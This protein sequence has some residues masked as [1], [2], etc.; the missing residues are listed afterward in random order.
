[1][2]N[3]GIIGLG[4]ISNTHIEAISRMPKEA[5]LVAVCDCNKEKKNKV[6][7]VNF[8]EN[9]E[10]MLQ[11]ERLDCL[12]ICLPH[13][14]HVPAVKLT[15]KYKVPVFVEKPVGLNTADVE[16]LERDEHVK[17]IKVG[18]CLQ[19]RYNATT[20]KM[21]EIIKGGAYGRLKGSKA[22]VTWDRTQNYYDKDPW[23]GKLS[24]A[25]GGVM[26][27]QAIH[28][29]DLMGLFCGKPQWVKGLA[30]SMLL[31]EIEVEDTACAY[32]A[33]E[34]GISGNFYGTVSH[35]TNSSIEL[36]LVFEAGT[37]YI[38]NNRLILLQDHVETV[39]AEDN[40][41]PGGKDYY[42]YSHYN[43]IRE[44]YQELQG[45]GG[46]HISIEE[47]QKVSRLIDSITASARAG[48][49]IYF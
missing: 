8:Y 22:I 47:A 18:V 28:T 49:R 13:H 24:E 46:S 26:L 48:E 36:E 4:V 43:A 31:E 42:G 21:Q 11:R 35:C 17:N 5:A 39:F 12:H 6:P 44:F 33:F 9:L 25:G 38:K 45:I 14:L 41:L 7:G 23:R 2:L 27:S 37:F 1:M 20:M 40:I 29:L 16:L 32:I 30:G 15:A 19:N 34:G 10:T 3:I